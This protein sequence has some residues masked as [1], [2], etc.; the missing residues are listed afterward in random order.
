[1]STMPSLQA[2]GL[3]PTARAP[4]RSD[5][6][7]TFLA[8]RAPRTLKAYRRDL[9]DFRRF[10][11]A[12]DLEAAA[13]TLLSQPPGEANRLVLLYR[14]Q[15]KER[16]LQ[17]TTINRRLAALRSLVKLARTVGLVSWALEVQNEKV[18][19]YR[20]TAG[21]G[22]SGLR[23]LLGQLEGHEDR[24]SVRDQAI[25]R[26]LYDLALRVSEVASLDRE[27]VDLEAGRVAVC[28]KGRS[29]QETLSVPTPTQSALAAWVELRGPDPGPLF[30]NVDRAGKGSGRITRQGIHA[31]VQKLGQQAGIRVWPHGLRHTAITEACKAAQANGLDLEEVLDFSRHADVRTLMV[32][33]DRER[34]VQGRLATLVA[35]GV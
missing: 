10:L 6:I 3:E 1:M 18:V 7:D 21:P 25:V 19:P 14:H 2:L 17:P 11:G 31:L 5:L 27:D 32:Y 20:D 9:E 8:G 23:L 24:K 35:A 30:P 33:R 22:L 29:Q 12:A 16:G 15:L 13:R 26:L 28:G 34:N 4:D